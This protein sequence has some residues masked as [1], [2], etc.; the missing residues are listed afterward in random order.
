MFFRRF[1]KT[2]PKSSFCEVL[3]FI[4]SSLVNSAH[5]IKQKLGVQSV[6]NIKIMQLA[7]IHQKR[8]TRSEKM[9]DVISFEM[10]AG[11]SNS[12]SYHSPLERDASSC[13]SLCFPVMHSV[14]LKNHLCLSASNLPSS[15]SFSIL[16]QTRTSEISVTSKNKGL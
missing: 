8:N 1:S 16:K 10:Y 15:C 7:R 12:K 13:G 5:F 14:E 9:L 2:V 11:K 3:R 4:S 6:Q